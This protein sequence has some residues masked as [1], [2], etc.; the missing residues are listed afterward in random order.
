MENN[1]DKTVGR[2]P[3]RKKGGC[4]KWLILIGGAIFIL[5]FCGAMALDPGE[6]PED[7]TT[8]QTE[9][10]SVEEEGE[11]ENVVIDTTATEIIDIYANNELQGQKQFEGQSVSFTGVVDD[12]VVSGSEAYILMGSATDES[13][14]ESLKAYFPEEEVDVLIGVNTGET[15]RIEGVVSGLNMF[16]EVKVTESRL[17]E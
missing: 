7:E 11:T 10:V 2:R 3:K 12:V 15:V 16:G 14:L 1:K 6:E 17:V 9:Q 4:L 13:W 8:E 5:G